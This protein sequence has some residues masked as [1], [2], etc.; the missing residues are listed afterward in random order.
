MGTVSKTLVNR[1][2]EL[3]KNSDEIQKRIYE[4]KAENALKRSQNEAEIFD[5]GQLDA[6]LKNEEQ[7]A[8][9]NKILRTNQA[10]ISISKGEEGCDFI[11]EI[12]IDDRLETEISYHKQDDFI[13]RVEHD[14]PINQTSDLVIHE[15]HTDPY[16][17]EIEGQ[18]F[19]VFDS[20]SMPIIEINQ[21]NKKSD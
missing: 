21:H 10:D 17:D 9:I 12:S 8:I 5:Y 3:E 18:I 16:A 6:A 14:L 11:I 4:L 13:N 19:E 7:R 1:L 20:A 2:E 15:D